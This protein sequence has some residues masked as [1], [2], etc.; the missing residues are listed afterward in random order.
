MA[1]QGQPPPR[2]ARAIEELLVQQIVS[3]AA[4]ETF[5]EGIL[6]GLARIDVVPWRECLTP[7]VSDPADAVFRDGQASKRPANI[8]AS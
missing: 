1:P 6:L 3:Q 8:M 4:G 5:D 7:C 2:I